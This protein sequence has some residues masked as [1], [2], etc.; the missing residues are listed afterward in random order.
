MF[1]LNYEKQTPRESHCLCKSRTLH[2]AMF[3]HVLRFG[4]IPSPWWQA[5]TVL[6]GT[7]S[8]LSL[9]VAVTAVSACCITYVVHSTTAKTAGVLQL[10]A[11]MFG[12]G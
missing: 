1:E 2:I 10:I 7:G 12:L 3:P 11:G 6:V 8:A 9:L 4:D 5:S